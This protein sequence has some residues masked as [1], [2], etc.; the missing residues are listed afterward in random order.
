MSLWVTYLVSALGA[1]VLGSLVL[2]ILVGI[3]PTSTAGF[4]LSLYVSMLILSAIVITIC[5]SI[6]LFAMK[7]LALKLSQMPTAAT[8]GITALVG[9]LS[10][11]VINFSIMLLSSDKGIVGKFFGTGGFVYPLVIGLIYGCAFGLVYSKVRG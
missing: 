2:W 8:V 1:S 3:H 6:L 4:T 10:Y 5:S 11:F 9:G 7:P